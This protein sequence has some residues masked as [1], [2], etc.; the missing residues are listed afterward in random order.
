[1]TGILH[2]S[3]SACTHRFNGH[4]PGK[5]VLTGFPVKIRVLNRFFAGGMFFLSRNQQRQQRTIAKTVI[6]YDP[7]HTVRDS[8]NFKP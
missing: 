6:Y 1:M 3:D 5:P 4:F 8:S 2:M 7:R